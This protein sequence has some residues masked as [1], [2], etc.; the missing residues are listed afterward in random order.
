MTPIENPQN[1]LIAVESGVE[2]HFITFIIKLV[3]PT[4]INLV[5]TTYILIRMF[6]V[7]DQE[8]NI[9]LIP[10]EALK[11]KRDA[12]LAGLGI[13]LTIA[14]LLINDVLELYRAPHTKYRGIIS[15]VVVAG[16]YMLT[17]NPRNILIGVD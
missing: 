13:A 14:L 2:A 4:I 16:I 9:G 1:M 11:N 3:L 17:T 5:M 12:V 8:I 7:E 15:F 6:R 10:H